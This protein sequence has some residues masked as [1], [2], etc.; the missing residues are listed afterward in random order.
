MCG[1]DRNILDSSQLFLNERIPFSN[2]VFFLWHRKSV[3]SF[4]FIYSLHHNSTGV[5]TSISGCSFT[6]FWPI[7]PLLFSNLCSRNKCQRDLFKMIKQADTPCQFIRQVL[8]T[9]SKSRCHTGFI[10]SRHYQLAVRVYKM[11]KHVDQV[12]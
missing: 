10:T 2:P 12:L 7:F 8:I 9:S 4:I 6:Y 3:F 5:G 11:I 1:Q